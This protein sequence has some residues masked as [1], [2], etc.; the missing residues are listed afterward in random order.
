MAQRILP[1][2]RVSIIVDARERNSPVFDHLSQLEVNLIQKQLEVGDYICSERVV[3]ERKTIRDF[4]QSIIDQR[5]FKQSSDLI[6]SFERPVLILEGNPELLFLEREIHPNTI[7]GVLAS[8]VIDYKI[9]IL[10]T[11]NSKDSASQIFWLARREQIKERKELAIR[12]M[13]KRPTFA[14][15]QEFL[16]AGLPFV[17]RKLSKRL[18]KKFKTPRKVFSARQEQLTKVEGI[19]KKKAKGIYDLLNKEYEGD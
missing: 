3:V 5:V 10:W 16:I 17:N 12:G 2:E 14:T 19:G 15:Q 4:L 13:K 1:G 11:A 6:E 8:I 18:L 7:R 9:P